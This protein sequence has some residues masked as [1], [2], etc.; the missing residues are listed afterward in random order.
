MFNRC[1]N[2][3]NGLC[4]VGVEPHECMLADIVGDT[5]NEALKWRLRKRMEQSQNR[6]T[7][8]PESSGKHFW[9]TGLITEEQ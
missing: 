7:C 2:A 9:E 6:H 5:N 3:G 1:N 4:W 8:G